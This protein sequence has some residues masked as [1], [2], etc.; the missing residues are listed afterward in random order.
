MTP[1]IA[2]PVASFV[3]LENI[4][5]PENARSAAVNNSLA[6]VSVSIHKQTINTAE[7]ATMLAKESFV[8]FKDSVTVEKDAVIAM[9]AV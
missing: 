3:L 2:D 8:A 6:E 9:D 1:S 5:R 4:A 7:N